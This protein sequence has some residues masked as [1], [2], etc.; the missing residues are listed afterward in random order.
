[1]GYL[2]EMLKFVKI[3]LKFKKVQKVTQKGNYELKTCEIE[4]F[5]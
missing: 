5:N 1:M 2:K 4:L 3:M